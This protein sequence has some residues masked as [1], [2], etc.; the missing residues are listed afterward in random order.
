MRVAGIPLVVHRSWYIIAGLIT[1]SLA[2]G[3]F[4]LRYAG[5]PAPTYW[6]MGLTAALL[7]FGCVLLHE[8][9]HSIVARWYGIPV[10][11]VTLFIFG[12]VAQIGREAHRPG[13][14]L[15]VALAGP[16]VSVL[17]AAACLLGSA[18]LPAGR[19]FA[20]LALPILRYLAAINIGI[21]V[22][23]LL[24]GFPLDGGRVLR[25]VLW[26]FTGSLRRATRIASFF[27]M[28]LGIGLIVLGAWE[29]AVRGLWAGGFWWVILGS[30]L[31][32]VAFA[33]YRQSSPPPAGAG[34]TQQTA[35][36]RSID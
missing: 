36:S 23:N 3:Y 2:T 33:T 34:S 31:Q 25:A 14:E 16:L 32:S 30:Y 20:D 8:L 9:G 13:V 1:W 12:G 35:R 10:Y 29:M 5:Y 7:L 15:Q 28:T 24:P 22:F 27:G 17:L 11:R 21:I 6:I 18:H 4:P 19:L 26:L